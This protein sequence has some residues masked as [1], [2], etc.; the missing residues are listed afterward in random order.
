[1]DT[2]TEDNT[3]HALR[4]PRCVEVCIVPRWAV[5]M[6]LDA[7]WFVRVSPLGDYLGVFQVEGREQ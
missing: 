3:P 4:D 6:N 5:E 7:R 1:M 2:L